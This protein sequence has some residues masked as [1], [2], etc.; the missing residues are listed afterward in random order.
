MGGGR[1]WSLWVVGGGGFAVGV[2]LGVAR[3]EGGGCDI[4]HGGMLP[5]LG[6]SAKLRGGRAG[7]GGGWGG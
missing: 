2:S 4:P 7:G 5:S 3:E 6:V 1:T